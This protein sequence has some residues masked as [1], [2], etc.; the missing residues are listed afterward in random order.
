[1]NKEYPLVTIITP[2]YNRVEFLEQTILSILEQDYPNIEYIVVDDGSEDNTIELLKRYEDRIT[3]V[4]HPNMG[5]TRTVNKG[6]Q[7]SHGE[8]IGVVNSDDLLL[9]GAIQAVVKTF[10]ENP[11][12]LVA[13]PGWTYIDEKSNPLYEEFVPEYD[14]TEMVRKHWCVVGPGAFIH[15]RAFEFTELRDEKFKYVADFEFWLRLGLYGPFKRID[16]VY[17]TFRIHGSSASVQMK[18]TEMGTEHIYL[19]ENYFNLS[20]VP[21]HLK[22]GRIYREAWSRAYLHAARTCPT[23]SSKANKFYIK[24][25]LLYPL[26]LVEILRG[27]FMKPIAYVSRATKK[28]VSSV[29]TKRR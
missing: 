17:G 29:S 1:M 3:W 6:Y 4:S 14:Y 12:I 23:T 5:E 28:R 26:I 13:Y 21:A 18:N 19:M 9:P 20:E 25:F 22:S 16:G 8:Y 2:T 24:S 11:D 27:I 15:R 7:M 10:I